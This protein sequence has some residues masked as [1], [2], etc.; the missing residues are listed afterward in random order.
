MSMPAIGIFDRFR[1]Q[2]FGNPVRFGVTKHACTLPR[3]G[4]HSSFSIRVLALDTL[5]NLIG[6][7]AGSLAGGWSQ[8][9]P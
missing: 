5:V 9:E 8:V 4:L 2:S 1:T 3:W 7:L 6:L